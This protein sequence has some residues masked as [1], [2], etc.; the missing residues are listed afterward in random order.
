MV[1]AKVKNMQPR[2]AV[3][4]RSPRSRRMNWPTACCMIAV[5]LIV[6][7]ILVVINFVVITK[8]A[9]RIAEA[10]AP[11]S[12]ARAYRRSGRSCLA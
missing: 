3:L 1:A 8:G 7:A 5:G 2:D 6:F 4:A 10:A 11:R 9:G 12:E